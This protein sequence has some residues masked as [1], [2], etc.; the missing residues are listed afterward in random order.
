M[1]SPVRQSLGLD[2]LA[3]VSSRALPLDDGAVGR[4]A[5]NVKRPRLA[6]RKRAGELITGESS[7]RD[8]DRDGLI[9][10]GQCCLGE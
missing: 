6:I 9:G 2:E 4:F 8:G 10:K 1:Q 3:F 7:R 5:V